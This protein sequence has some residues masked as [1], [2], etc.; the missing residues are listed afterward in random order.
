MDLSLV[1]VSYNVKDRLQANLA[2]VYNNQ[3]NFSFEV[4][5]VDNNSGDGSAMMVRNGFPQ[6]KLIANS[7][8]LGFARAVN[9]GIKEAQGD[10]ILLLNPD[11]K[12]FPDSLEKIVQAAKANPQ[13]VVLG[14]QLVD[15]NGKVV[16][17]VRRFPKLFDQL[18]IVWKLPHLFPGLINSYL[19]SAFDYQKSAAVD[20]ARGSFFL[21]N[22][23]AWERISGEAK[24][25]FDER[26]FIWFEEVDF[27]RRVRQLGGKV[28]YTPQARVIDYVGQSFKQVER[29]QKQKYFRAS[30]LQYFS[31]WHPRWQTMVLRVA[32]WPLCLW[33]KK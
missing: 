30:M 16:F 15:E 7:N 28:Y 5:V 2:S 29:S 12:L 31:K 4:L 8:N 25:Y 3:T 14:G 20:S 27:C 21:I 26:Y 23:A 17:S 1:V 6:V 19:M 9:Q 32:W 33:I 11:M 22:I 18:A 10:Y 24:P 13:A